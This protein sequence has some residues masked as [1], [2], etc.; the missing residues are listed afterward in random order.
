V[1]VRRPL[2]R[3]RLR[4]TTYGAWTASPWWARSWCPSLWSCAHQGGFLFVRRCATRT[5]P[6][7]RWSQWQCLLRRALHRRQRGPHMR[8]QPR[9]AVANGS[10]LV[11]RPTAC[12]CSVHCWTPKQPKH[13][14][15]P[16]DVPASPCQGFQGSRTKC[17][18]CTV[19]VHLRL[20]AGLPETSVEGT[21]VTQ[22]PR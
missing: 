16:E 3:R 11:S 20:L 10:A 22:A 2:L 15:G 18:Q 17:V 21:L 1:R 19:P 14:T 7:G 8:R 12:T 4:L 13:Q 5:S 6:M 9:Q